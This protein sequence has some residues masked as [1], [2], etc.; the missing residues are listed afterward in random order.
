MTQYISKLK[1]QSITIIDQFIILRCRKLNWLSWEFSIKTCSGSNPQICL[2]LEPIWR[3]RLTLAQVSPRKKKHV[4]KA[5]EKHEKEWK[6]TI[7]I[8]YKVMKKRHALRPLHFSWHISC[9]LPFTD[10]RSE[11]LKSSMT[12]ARGD[13]IRRP[14]IRWLRGSDSDLWLF[15]AIHIPSYSLLNRELRS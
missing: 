1:G 8:N 4:R 9:P 10:L 14:Y 6:R 12:T 11:V 13:A 7:V 5:W 15:N 2:C 3:L